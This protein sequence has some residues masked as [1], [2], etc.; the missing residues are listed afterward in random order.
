MC[1]QDGYC[2][3]SCLER[4]VRGLKDWSV[5]ALVLTEDSNAYKLSRWGQF[6][7]SSFS[8]KNVDGAF[9]LDEIDSN[10]MGITLNREIHRSLSDSKVCDGDVL[11]KVRQK[12][13]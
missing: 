1:K 5:E 11:K 10:P 8:D 12:G 7:P 13:G 6:V 4:L 9:P 3:P 2:D